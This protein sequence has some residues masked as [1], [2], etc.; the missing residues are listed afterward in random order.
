MAR[1]FHTSV[2]CGATIVRHRQAPDGMRAA[3]EVR[4]GG[5]G[6]DRATSD[7]R[8]TGVGVRRSVLVDALARI[9]R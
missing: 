7:D 4:E 2:G 5:L 8:G 6:E 1:Y 3:I 9:H